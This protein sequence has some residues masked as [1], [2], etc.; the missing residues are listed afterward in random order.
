MHRHPSLDTLRTFHTHDLISDLA[1][2]E[3]APRLLSL[4]VAVAGAAREDKFAEVI[5][6]SRNRMVDMPLALI[7]HEPLVA[8]AAA[9]VEVFPK[10]SDVGRTRIED[11][12][13]GSPH[14]VLRLRD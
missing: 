11:L 13:D 7:T 14:P 1:V 2:Q 5:P 6:A 4:L 3:I 8:V 10:R 9:S 12:V